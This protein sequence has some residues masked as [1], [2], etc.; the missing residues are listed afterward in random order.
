ML[1]NLPFLRASDEKG[2]KGKKAYSLLVPD[3]LCLKMSR[4][5]N[6]QQP[7]YAPTVCPFYVFHLNRKHLNK[8]LIYSIILLGSDLYYKGGEICYKK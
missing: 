4:F 3:K 2:A 6:K 7:P 8:F 5:A 1:K